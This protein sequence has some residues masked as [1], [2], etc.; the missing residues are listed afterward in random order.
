MRIILILFSSTLL[1]SG[2]TTSS[3]NP[4]GRSHFKPIDL[5]NETITTHSLF[6]EEYYSSI[7]KSE[8]WVTDPIDV[9]L[10]YAGFPNP[11][12]INPDRVL[13]YFLQANKAVVIITRDNLLDD[14]IS[15]KEY[16][17][18]LVKQENVWKIEWAGYRLKCGRGLSIGWGKGPCP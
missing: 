1:F 17:I 13:T 10:R 12:K 11:D 5:E 7:E 8:D 9:A 4:L 15:A 3:N 16:R 2:C 18:D 6:W 14:S